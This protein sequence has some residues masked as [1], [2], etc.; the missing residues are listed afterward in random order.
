MEENRHFSIIYFTV[1]KFQDISVIQILR[2]INLRELG[3][4][5]NSKTSVFAIC[6]FRNFDQPLNFSNLVHFGPSKS[7]K[8]HGNQNAELVN[9]FRLQILHF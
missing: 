3:E 5:R 7:A 6:H 1:W 9:V 8:I 2:E 4:S